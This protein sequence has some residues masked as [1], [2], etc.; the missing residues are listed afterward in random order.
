VLFK[1]D[2][3]LILKILHILEGNHFFLFLSI[4][5]L[6]KKIGVIMEIIVCKNDCEISWRCYLH[7]SN[8]KKTKKEGNNITKVSLDCNVK[9]HY[10]KFINKEGYNFEGRK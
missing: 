4:L 3:L 7:E 9:N 10:R 2:Y 8:H 6:E 5:I 1:I